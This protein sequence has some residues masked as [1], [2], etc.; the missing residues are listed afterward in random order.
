MMDPK[1]NASPIA[2]P[3]IA[4]A[5]ASHHTFF[6]RHAQTPTPIEA[7]AG[8][9]PSKAD[10]GNGKG[11]VFA[12]AIQAKKKMLAKAA[13]IRL[14]TARQ[15]RPNRQPSS[16]RAPDTKVPCWDCIDAG[17]GP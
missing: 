3:A 15:P 14:T 9:K 8:T 4:F 16:F 17:G 11:C 1:A 10:A 2:P 7:S 12:N 13:L 5:A 6:S